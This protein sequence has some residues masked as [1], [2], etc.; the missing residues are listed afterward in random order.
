MHSRITSGI[1]L[2]TNPTKPYPM[3]IAAQIPLEQ[4]SAPPF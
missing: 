4:N 1:Q 3:A 2:R